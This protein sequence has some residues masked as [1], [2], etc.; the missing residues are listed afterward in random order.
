MGSE[1]CRNKVRFRLS[2]RTGALRFESFDTV[3][4]PLCPETARS[5]RR[6]LVGQRFADVNPTYIWQLL[7]PVL[8]MLEARS[9]ERP[10]W[11]P[12]LA[13]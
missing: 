13:T 5:L 7:R 2:D 4:A 12:I 8:P 3:D 11:R 1:D 6:Y 10:F 9:A